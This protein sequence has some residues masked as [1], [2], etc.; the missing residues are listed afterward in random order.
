MK[1]DR[2]VFKYIVIICLK[3][4]LLNKPITTKS[5]EH[6][7]NILFQDFCFYLHNT[8]IKAIVENAIV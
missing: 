7:K 5:R 8:S 6:Y 4:S 3:N 2:S 1:K